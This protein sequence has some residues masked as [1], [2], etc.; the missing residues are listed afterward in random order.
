MNEDMKAAATVLFAYDTNCSLDT[1]RTYLEA[2]SFH[3]E[4]A[5]GNLMFDRNKHLPVHLQV[6]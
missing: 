6:A 5:R 2:A 3:M 1:A 4:D